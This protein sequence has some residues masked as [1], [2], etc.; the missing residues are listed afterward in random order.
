MCSSKILE[1]LRFAG[2]EYV[3]QVFLQTCKAYALD[4]HTCKSRFKALNWV[5]T[6][7]SVDVTVKSPRNLKN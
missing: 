6:L 2:I 5:A 4:S 7:A 1:G 3:D